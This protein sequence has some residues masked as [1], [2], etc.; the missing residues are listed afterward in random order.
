MCNC[1]FC[2]DLQESFSRSS[3][4]L[5]LPPRCVFIVLKVIAQC[6]AHSSEWLVNLTSSSYVPLRPTGG[7]VL[8]PRPP[9]AKAGPG[10]PPPPRKEASQP[11]AS[12]SSVAKGASPNLGQHQAQRSSKPSK[13]G[14]ALPPRPKPGHRLYNKYTVS[15]LCWA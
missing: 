5:S 2:F 12:V 7:K 6:I 11:P 1:C 14:P 3:P 8:P 9:P 15:I 4:D 13:K 10:R